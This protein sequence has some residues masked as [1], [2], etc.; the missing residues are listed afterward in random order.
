MIVKKKTKN[1]PSPKVA[2]VDIGSNSVRLVIYRKTG[3][4]YDVVEDHKA[5]CRLAEGM[6]HKAPRLHAMGQQKTLKTLTSFR[7]LLIRRK[8]NQVRAIGT[9]AMRAVA[10]TTAGQKFHHKAEAAL[11]CKIKVISGRKEA[12][13]TALGVMSSLPNAVGIC[14]DLGGGSLELAQIDH[15]TIF[16][17]TTIPLGSLTLVSESGHDVHQAQPLIQKRLSK[18]TWLTDIKGKNLYVIG[19]SWRA[20][21]RVMMLQGDKAQPIHGYKISAAKA[22]PLLQKMV[23][24]TP[25]SFQTM[26]SKIKRRADVIP[27]A[28]AVLLE[29]VEICRP[30][31]IVFSG[32]GVREGLVLSSFKD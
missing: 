3:R 25:S 24:Q 16:H 13:L 19:G 28:A 9:A 23:G 15:Q 1:K 12:E 27:W 20:V 6:T 10:K 8:V 31:A 7:D 30:R 5:E 29:L 11:G 18:Q 14:G 17:T 21:G 2:V 26:G 22:R 4:H 32:H